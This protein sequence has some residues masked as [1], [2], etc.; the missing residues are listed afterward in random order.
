MDGRARWNKKMSE[1]I[2]YRVY[3]NVKFNFKPGLFSWI[4]W[5]EVIFFGKSALLVFW[6][7]GWENGPKV[8]NTQ[9]KCLFHHFGGMLEAK[10][11]LFF[12]FRAPEVPFFCTWKRTLLPK[13]PNF[14]YQKTV[15]WVPETKNGDHFFTPTSP[16]NGGI[17]ICSVRLSLLSGV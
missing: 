16:Q 3:S 13:V 2:S 15:L 17:D 4:F 12:Q 1:N 7:C 9:N 11:G 6:P 5:F 8:I 14:G 10:S